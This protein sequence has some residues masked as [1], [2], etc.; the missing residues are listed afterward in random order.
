MKERRQD[1]TRKLNEMREEETKCVDE[2]A[3]NVARKGQMRQ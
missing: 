3:G 2:T 1:K